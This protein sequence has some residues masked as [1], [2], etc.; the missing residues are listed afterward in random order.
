MQDIHAPLAQQP[1]QMQMGAKRPRLMCVFEQLEI[2]RKLIELRNVPPLANQQIVRFIVNARELID[3]VAD[4]GAQAIIP[5]ATYIDGHAHVF[6]APAELA[7]A[8]ARQF[9]RLRASAAGT[10]EIPRL[11][12]LLRRARA[13]RSR[14]RPR[15]PARRRS[16]P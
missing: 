4:V 13:A 8:K 16:S 9:P 10:T 12:A 2:L 3:D 15:V 11:A 1:R 6:L 7:D 5:G 14:R